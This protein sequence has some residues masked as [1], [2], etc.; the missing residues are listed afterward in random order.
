MSQVLVALEFL[1]EHCGI[2]HCN[3][4]AENILIKF[5]DNEVVR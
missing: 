4:K 5:P 3:L 2:V 1:H